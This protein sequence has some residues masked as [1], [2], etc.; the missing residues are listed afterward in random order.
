MLSAEAELLYP[1]VVIGLNAV[2]IAV[3]DETPCVLTVKHTGHTRTAQQECVPTTVGANLPDALPFGPLE[4]EYHQT[5]ERGLRHWVER[6][7]GMRLGYVEQLYT[8]GDRFR[9]PGAR[10]GGPQVISVASSRRRDIQLQRIESALS[11]IEKDEYGICT[12]CGEDIDLKRLQ[13]DPTAFLCIDCARRSE[14]SA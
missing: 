10:E 11:R 6:Q 7:T 4:P 5:L 9:D 14:R 12:S 1:P 3:T 8:F 2:I 13:F